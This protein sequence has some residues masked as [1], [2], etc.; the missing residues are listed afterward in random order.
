MAT[1]VICEFNPFHNGHKYLLEKTK[2]ITGEPVIAIMSGSFTQRGEAAITDKFSRAEAALQNGA[3]L[4]AEL[5]AVYALSNA[6]RFARCGAEI[7]KSFK[8]VNHLAFGCET[9]DVAL[10]SRAAQSTKNSEVQ[11]LINT[12]MKG[13]GYYPRALE[14]AVRQV[15]GDEVADV[16]TA[17]NNILAVEYLRSIENSSIKP[18]AIERRGAAHDSRSA[19]G[20][21]ASASYIRE[22]MRKNAEFKSFV[23]CVP[24][25][26]AYPE[27]L[28]RVLLYRLRSM[29]AEDFRRLPDV[30]EGLENRI[31]AAVSQYNSAEEI[32]SAVK[33]KRYTH[34]RIRR[35]LCCALLEITEELQ[36]T[37]VEYVR[38]LGFNSDGA[39]LLKSC[40]FNVVTSASKGL[41]LGGSVAELL[42]K[43]IYSTDVAALAYGK[44]RRSGEDYTEQIKRTAAQTNTR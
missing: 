2:E 31:V 21:I 34:A 11:K 41:K 35:I 3:D 32:I 27:N 37:P 18:L 15:L 1:A 22:L 39:S 17:P 14:S 6:Q 29:T 44:I 13:G 23:P 9:Q 20:N 36:S 43:D 5:P 4:V 16:L 33:T 8:C 40:E 26:I 24:E 25:S 38:V 12:E 19:S 10:L 28:E 42:Q 30:N 7:A